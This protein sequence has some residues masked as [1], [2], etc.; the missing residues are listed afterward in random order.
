MTRMQET[1]FDDEEAVLLEVAHAL[2]ADPDEMAIDTDRGLEGFGTGTVY[3]IEW[4]RQEYVVVESYDQMNALALEV[5]KQDLEEDPSMFN[6]AFIEQHINMDRLR[7]DLEADVLNSRI[8]DLAYEADLRPDDFWDE[9][10]R[11][12][13]DAPEE[14]EDGE[15]RPPDQIEIEELAEKQTDEMLSD[16]MRYLED[17]Y[18][19]E[20]AKQ[21][22]EIAGIDIDAAAE[23]AVD[24]DGA[25]HFLA[26]YDSNDYETNSGLVYWRDN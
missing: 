23:D 12:G 5:V 8:D 18:G 14:D 15:R 7:R 19:D 6:Q 10:E 13:F 22:I 25:A 17:I 9:Y 16:P 1:D 11:E 4:G 20:A 21:A 3:R 2:E 24:T 26:R